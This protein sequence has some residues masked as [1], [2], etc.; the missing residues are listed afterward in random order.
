MRECFSNDHVIAEHLKKNVLASQIATFLAF[1]SDLGYSPSTIRTKL[2]LLSSLTRWIQKN[3]VNIFHIDE[4]ITNRFL[5]ESGRKGACRR[6]DQKT[7]RCFLDHLRTESLID[8]P[9]L[10]SDESP[11]TSIKNRYEYYLRKERG[12]S[13][14]TAS[15]YWLVLQR[16]LLERFNDGPLLFC[17]L[18]QQDIDS[19]LLRHAH[20]RT[21]KVALLMV[22]TMR[23]FFHFLFRFGETKHDLSVIVPTVPSW[24]LTEVPKYLNPDE[25]ETIL[26]ACDRTTSVGRRDYS[27]LLLIARLGLR[28]GEVVTLTLD[29]INWRTAELMVRGKGQF[30]DCLPLPHE[31][32]KTLA[33]YLRNDRP[34][35]S[36][37]RIFLRMRAPLRGFKD[38][39]SVSTIVRRAVQR[40]GLNTP[41][42]GAHLLRHSLATGML[43]NGASMAEIGELLRHRSPNSTEIYAKVDIEGLRSIAR[44]WPEKGGVR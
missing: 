31:I 40:S 32:G 15:R 4:N 21:P 22:T 8:S 27:I 38:S 42:K 14:V 34:I 41:S 28:A 1:V 25:L 7:L 13:A 36:S 17:E 19:F 37:R 39:T 44:S 6:G 24:R 3:D 33:T 30:C 16:F 18:G 29:D 12:L 5:S 23:S 35:C 43:H 10:T 26:E 11:L 20:E 9:V 2:E